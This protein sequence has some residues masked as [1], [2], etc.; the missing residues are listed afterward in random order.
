LKFFGV[1]GHKRQLIFECCG[2]YENDH[3]PLPAQQMDARIGVEEMVER[4][5]GFTDSAGYISAMTLTLPDIPI[6]ARMS[7]AELRIELAC[8]LYS[9]GR[10]SAVAGSH[11]AETDLVSFQGALADRDIP[12]SYSVSDLHSDLAAMDRI[13]GA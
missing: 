7:E 9:R 4:A 12:R 8:A 5:L 3:R 13:L 2:R 6:T 11:L 10:I 1:V